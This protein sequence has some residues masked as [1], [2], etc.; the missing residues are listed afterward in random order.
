M[1][2]NLDRSS[3]TICLSYVW[4]GAGADFQGGEGGVTFFR[5]DFQLGKIC[6]FIGSSCFHFLSLE[7]HVLYEVFKDGERV[8]KV[9]VPREKNISN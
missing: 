4:V 8:N 3:V 5:R 7:G 6:Y 1:N 2:R 9:I